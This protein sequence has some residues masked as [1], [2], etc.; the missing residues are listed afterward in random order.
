MEHP[1]ESVIVT[2]CHSAEG[3]AV[4]TS[5]HKESAVAVVSPLS[6]R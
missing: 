6:Q 1:L 3:Q 5:A 2:P 4:F